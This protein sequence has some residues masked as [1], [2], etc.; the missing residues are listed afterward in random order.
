MGGRAVSMEFRGF[1]AGNGR[2]T[3]V[4]ILG[5]GRPG[6]GCH[7]V[8]DKV[9]VGQEDGLLGR[10]QGDVIALVRHVGS[11]VYR[12]RH[13]TPGCCACLP[14]TTRPTFATLP[15]RSTAGAVCGAF[16]RYGGWALSH[17]VC[18][19]EVRGRH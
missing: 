12:C 18:G 1:G 8:K 4:A 7:Q 17:W 2:A 9:L 16:A 6:C 19:R 14:D 3:K 11:T 13:G 10:R 5:C 15:V